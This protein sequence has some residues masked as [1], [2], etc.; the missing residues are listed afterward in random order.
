MFRLDELFEAFSKAGVTL[1]LC[2]PK[3]RIVEGAR[4]LPLP[5]P[6]AIHTLHEL[7]EALLPDGKDRA[8]C[9]RLGELALRGETVSLARFVKSR[10]D[11]RD[12]PMVIRVAPSRKGL[13][14]MLV[15]FG[16]D[17][18]VPIPEDVERL[19]GL[20][21]IAASAS[22]EFNNV[23]TSILGW[24]QIAQKNPGPSETLTSALEIIESN[25][26]RAKTLAYDLTG[27]SSQEGDEREPLALGRS[28]DEVL[29]FLAWR[30]ERT[31][32]E[33]V[34]EGTAACR[35]LGSP[36]RLYQVWFNLVLNAIEAMPGGGTL[37]VALEEQGGLAEVSIADTGPGV[38]ADLRDRIFEPYFTTKRRSS[39]AGTGG[40]GLGL[41]LCRRIVEEH[42]GRI[43]VDTADGGGARFRVLLPVTDERPGAD[44]PEVEA[45]LETDESRPILR[46][47]VV[48]DEDDIREMLR[49]SLGLK[50]ITVDTAEDGDQA[51]RQ[52]GSSRY[53]VVL[54]DYSMPG[55]P[56]AE[57]IRAP[58]PEPRPAFVLLTG[59]AE[60]LDGASLEAFDAR[61][62]LAA[63]LV[64]GFQRSGGHEAAL[65][66]KLVKGLYLF[67]LTTGGERLV[68]IRVRLL[69]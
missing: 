66:G 34:R 24:A 38:P 68:T 63:V 8:E 36:Q 47:L 12:Q 21:A 28:L 3:G 60:V 53:D 64:D 1:V 59:R 11:G 27:V 5:D 44:R 51:V 46:V 4:Y 57:V 42:G 35:I 33:V 69:Y 31:G 55:A 39:D 13:A 14:V 29:R 25:A 9:N 20:G 52:L 40:T 7:F 58:G 17:H 23:L 56:A 54:L 45:D 22:H 2:D 15:R 41:S 67:R 30:L 61:G 37:R 48:D 65:S 32:I 10:V 62:K 19:A 6:R 18:S 16:P 50:G 26:K 49:I 43:S